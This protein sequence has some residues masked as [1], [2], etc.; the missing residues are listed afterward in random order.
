VIR[1]FLIQ[2]MESVLNIWLKA[3]IKAHDFIA[4]EYWL[5]NVEAMRD[6]YLPNADVFVYEDKAILGFY[7]LV[8]NHLAAIFVS[9]DQ[10]GKG[11]GKCLMAHA[12]QQRDELS[13]SVYC[14]NCRSVDFYRAQG[15]SIVE[16][17]QDE[18]TGQEEYVMY[19]LK[20]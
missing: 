6:V 20:K 10:Q 9:P 13:L 1:P 15:F 12:K 11:V 7:A 4:A 8:E 17:S 3:S 18:A 2:D 14:A 5:S 19:Y 16:R